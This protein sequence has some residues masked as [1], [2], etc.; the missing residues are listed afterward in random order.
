M[1]GGSI[2]LPDGAS[3]GMQLGSLLGAKVGIH[4]LLGTALGIVKLENNKYTLEITNFTIKHLAHNQY[5]ERWLG[6]PSIGPR[7]FENAYMLKAR[8]IRE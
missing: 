6:A 1:P 5:Y 3:L 7:N 2:D 8:A 4:T